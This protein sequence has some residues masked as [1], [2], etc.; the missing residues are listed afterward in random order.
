MGHTGKR[1]VYQEEEIRKLIDVWDDDD[2]NED[3]FGKEILP[4]TE[5]MFRGIV[6]MQ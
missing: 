2:I 5:D 4:L 3:F 6:G 1:Q